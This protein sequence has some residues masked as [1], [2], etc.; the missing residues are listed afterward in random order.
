M[1]QENKTQPTDVTAEEFLDSI[2]D[3]KKRA[4][5]Y[6][7]LDL[8][9]EVTGDPPVMWGDSIIGFGKYH[10]KYK[11]GQ[12][13]EFM[14]TGF[15]PRK[16]NL[17]IYVMPGFDVFEKLLTKLGKHKTSRSCLYVNKLADVDLDVLK[18]LIEADV[19]HMRELYPED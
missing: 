12:Q 14:R 11:S 4:D 8:F 10:Y 15:S 13:G 1:A 9:K 7:L 2:E 5:S 17:T 6:V 3:E 19:A 16:R 18:Q